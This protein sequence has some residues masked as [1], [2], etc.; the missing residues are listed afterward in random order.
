LNATI[1]SHIVPVGCQRKGLGQR[2]SSLAAHEKVL[3]SLPPR[4]V[5]ETVVGGDADLTG[6]LSSFY[7]RGKHSGE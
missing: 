4:D 7:T 2:A 6:R 5:F 3:P 1:C